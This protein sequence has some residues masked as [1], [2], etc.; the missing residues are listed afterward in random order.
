MDNTRASQRPA[1][2]PV[3]SEIFPHLLS[4][5]CNVLANAFVDGRIGIRVFAADLESNEEDWYTDGASFSFPFLGPGLVIDG[6]AVLGRR[7][8]TPLA[9]S[10]VF[11]QVDVGYHAPRPEVADH[12]ADVVRWTGWSQRKIAGILGTT[13]PTVARFAQNA[14]SSRSSSA[15][16]ALH[17]VHEVLE[18]L[19]A[20]NPQAN[21]LAA[22]LSERHGESQA[23]PEEL[24]QNHE[25]AGAYRLGL[26]SLSGGTPDMVGGSRFKNQP[27]TYPADMDG[28]V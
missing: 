10:I 17:R 4:G 13:H 22:I 27:A 5:T 26:L 7:Q 28:W 8:A 16:E 9:Q 18:R 20:V 12:L 6:R 23:S 21:D 19:A 25:Y 24:L 3:S 1:V 15:I 2:V 11:P 14:I